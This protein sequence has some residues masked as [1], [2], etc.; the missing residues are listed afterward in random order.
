MSWMLHSSPGRASEDIKGSKTQLWSL[1]YY[2]RGFGWN[3]GGHFC[4]LLV[5]NPFFQP[6]CL[7]FSLRKP[8]F[9]P[10]K[11]Q[12]EVAILM[13]R[14][15]APHPSQLKIVHN[16]DCMVGSKESHVTRSRLLLKRLEKKCLLLETELGAA[17]SCVHRPVGAASWE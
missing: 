8:T 7:G 1:F 4:Y 3:Q 9:E 14:A 13:S 5:Q 2:L 15:W 16:P 10:T 6:S 17:S 12:P 11:F